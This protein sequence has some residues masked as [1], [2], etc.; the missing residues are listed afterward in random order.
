[1]RCEGPA[2]S[3]PRGESRSLVGA[4]DTPGVAPPQRL[5]YHEAYRERGG[6]TPGKQGARHGAAGWGLRTTGFST[7]GRFIAAEAK[8]SATD[9]HQTKS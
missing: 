6:L 2:L 5:R 7:M 4:R 8:L 1:M 3:R 9:S